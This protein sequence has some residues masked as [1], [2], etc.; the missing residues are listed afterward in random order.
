MKGPSLQKTAAV[1]AALH[2][3]VFLISVLLL[4]QTNHFTIPSPYI[5]D[6]VGQDISVRTRGRADAASARSS[7]KH[8]HAAEKNVPKSERVSEREEQRIEDTIAALAAKRKIRNMLA[9]REKVLS[10]KASGGQ[11]EKGPLKS[12]VA[13]SSQG[14]RGSISYE[15]KIRNEIHR[16]WFCPD[17]GNKDLEA[18]ISL[19]IRK[20]GSLANIEMEKKSG[21]RLFNNCALQAIAKASPVTPPPEGEMT[22]GIRFYP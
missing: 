16:Q 22:I 9:L 2:V 8:P 6:L 14:M 5:V 15:D 10:I 1:S 21:S 18:I 11:T 19:T 17:T 3:T 4:K 13:G 20:D 7:V 12:P